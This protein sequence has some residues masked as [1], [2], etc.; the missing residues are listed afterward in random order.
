MKTAISGFKLPFATLSILLICTAVYQANAQQIAV[1]GEMVYTATGEP[2]A[3]GVV[4][5]SDGIIEEVGP[6]SG[7]QIP[8]GYE[9]LEA[10]V[11]T[12]GFIDAHSVVGLAGIY[13]VDDDQDQLELSGAI[14]PELRAIDGYNARDELVGVLRDRGITT[15]HTGH[16]PG[17][18]ISGQ[19]MIVKTIGTTVDQALVDSTTALAMTIGAVVRN[20]FDNPGTRSKAIAMLRQEL[21]RAQ[22]YNDRSENGS[23]D[24]KMEALTQLLNGEIYALITA[25]TSRDILTALRLQREFGFKLL[26][27]GA[28]EAYMVMDE[29]KE[30][31]VPVIIHPTMMRLGGDG[32]NASFETAGKLADAGITVLFQSGYEAYVPKTRVV[33]FEAAI[34]V[35]N[36][37]AHDQA[38]RA[39][40]IDAARVLGLEDS[41]GSIEEG[42]QADLVLFTG[43]PFEYTTTVTRVLING[44]VVSE[45]E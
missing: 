27:D 20:N 29:I 38:I 6:E 12:P 23:R 41:I 11:V 37:M 3:N 19:T 45:G 2:I 1:K 17:A 22:E 43:D 34:A 10:P 5:I 18:V 36:G 31:D 28:A 26:L 21:I 24:L 30:A 13:N 14:Q 15:V 44:E 39:L 32:E 40:T 16:G 7:V 33:H 35:A 9:I 4:L 42:K 8:S 25:H